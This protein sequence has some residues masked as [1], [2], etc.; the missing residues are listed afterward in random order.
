MHGI[1][2]LTATSRRMAVCHSTVPSLEAFHSLNLPFLYRTTTICRHYTAAPYNDELSALL[3]ELEVPKAE[4]QPE[5]RQSLRTQ[6]TVGRSPTQKPRESSSQGPGAIRYSRTQSRNPSY[7]VDRRRNARREDTRSASFANRIDGPP[8]GRLHSREGQASLGRNVYGR[9]RRDARNSGSRPLRDEAIDNFVPFEN[10]GGEVSARVHSTVTSKEYRAFERLLGSDIDGGGAPRNL[11][12]GS[13][14]LEEIAQEVARQKETSDSRKSGAV[15][16]DCTEQDIRESR[17]KAGR[18]SHDQLRALNRMRADVD[19]TRTDVELWQFTR[20]E[21]FK[22][23]KALRLD[24]PTA[25]EE[26]QRQRYRA[27]TA[28]SKMY[29]PT[30]GPQLQT[31]TVPTVDEIESWA[32]NLPPILLHIQAAFTSRFPGSPFALALL[33]A[34]RRLGHSAFT[35]GASTTLYNRHIRL[36]FEQRTD[37]TGIIKILEEMDRNVYTFDRNTHSSLIRIVRHSR[38][39]RQGEYGPGQETLWSMERMTRGVRNITKWMD[40]VRHRINEAALRKVRAEL[41]GSESRDEVVEDVADLRDPP[42]LPP[43]TYVT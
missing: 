8:L 19:A 36:L 7:V 39:A 3:T 21:I 4:Q 16:R 24:D 37:L 38:N 13:S 11:A 10:A 17:A 12:T 34:L 26:R 35:L 41:S 43:V 27:D 32:I 14:L 9:K 31:Q 6:E 20:N 30:E 29:Q 25:N 15:P 2:A 40:T 5:V 28:S 22:K 23:I 18:S 42:P 1:N 33:P